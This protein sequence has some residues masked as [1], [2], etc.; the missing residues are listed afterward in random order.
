MWTRTKKLNFPVC[1]KYLSSGKR[2]KENRLTCKLVIVGGRNKKKREPSHSVYKMRYFFFNYI[3]FRASSL[4][5]L[6]YSVY[7]TA[8]H[9]HF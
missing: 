8:T 4:S 2:K 6:M 7:F 3:N 5:K 9:L 1:R